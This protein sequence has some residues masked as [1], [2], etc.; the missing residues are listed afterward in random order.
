M[1]RAWLGNDRRP[2]S[3]DSISL[4]PDHRPLFP[5]FPMAEILERELD[6]WRQAPFFRANE[7]V[8][9]GLKMAGNSVRLIR[10]LLG[11]IIGLIFYFFP[12]PKSLSE[13]EGGT[14]VSARRPPLGERAAAD[15]RGP[16]GL[17]PQA[18]LL[19]SA[20]SPGP[21]RC[22]ARPARG[23]ALGATARSVSALSRSTSRCARSRWRRTGPSRW[24]PS[25]CSIMYLLFVDGWSTHF[26]SNVHDPTAQAKQPA[27]PSWTACL[28]D[29]QHSNIHHATWQGIPRNCPR[30]GGWHHRRTPP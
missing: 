16:Q 26:S 10:S 5:L 30:P 3:F 14:T 12:W 4:G 21:G 13:E 29:Q 22:W 2:G 6:R 1:F 27:N 8:V 23:G 7:F 24:S 28:Q 17:G 19:V 9:F 20:A 11:R 15:A 25:T 18:L